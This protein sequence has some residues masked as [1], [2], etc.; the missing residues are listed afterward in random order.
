MK[1]PAGLTVILFF[2]FGCQR[3]SDLSDVELENQVRALLELPTFEQI[4]KDIIYVDENKSFLM[5][6]TVDKRVLFSIDIKVQAGLDFHDGF[7]VRKVTRNEVEVY[8]PEAKILLVDA[9][10]SSIHEYFIK[11]KGDKITRLEYYDEINDKKDFIAKDAIDRGILDRAR[12]NAESLLTKLF[13]AIGF[14]TVIFLKF[15]QTLPFGDSD[16]K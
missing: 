12:Q 16:E 11:E 2:L 1:R 14:D 8:L 10:E 4:Y 15:N 13:H 3:S 9:D 7:S 6:K 5:F